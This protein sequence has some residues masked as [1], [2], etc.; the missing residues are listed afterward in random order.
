MPTLFPRLIMLPYYKTSVTKLQM[1]YYKSNSS[2][3][4]EH[5]KTDL[6]T[7]SAWGAWVARSF[8]LPALDFGS[9]HDLS[10]MRLSPMSRSVLGVEPA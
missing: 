10:V 9:S 6:R 7:D 4:V 3:I 2:Y 5:L 1:F 8:K